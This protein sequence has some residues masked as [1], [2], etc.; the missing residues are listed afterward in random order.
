MIPQRLAIVAIVATWS[1]PTIVVAQ[2][3][4]AEPAAAHTAAPAKEPSERGTSPAKKELAAEPLPQRSPSKEALKEG[5]GESAAKPTSEHAAVKSDGKGK[6]MTAR[7]AEDAKGPTHASA[8]KASSEKDAEPA[9]SGGKKVASTASARS[10]TEPKN[11]LDAALKRIDEQ[12]ATMRT[13]PS[14]AQSGKPRATNEARAVR[15]ASPPS[16]A[17]VHLSWRTALVWSPE[18]E[19]EADAARDAPHVEL[20]WATEPLTSTPIT[21]GSVH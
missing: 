7:Q 2:H 6:D 11:D 9:T 14:T 10:K 13:S 3:A 16:I 15:V 12:L 17:R 21:P 19:G 8:E 20:V 4:K 1:V 18:L 5:P